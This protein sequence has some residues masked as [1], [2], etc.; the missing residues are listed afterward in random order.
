MEGG[1]QHHFNR[2]SFKSLMVRFHS[3]SLM[4]FKVVEDEE[5]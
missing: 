1:Q 3:A 4:K 2:T 5:N